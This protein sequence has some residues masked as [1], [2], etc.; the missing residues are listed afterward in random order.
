MWEEGA[1]IGS[2]CK[3][4][5]CPSTCIIH[6]PI[7]SRSY[8][9]SG[10]DHEIVKKVHVAQSIGLLTNSYL[11]DHLQ[12]FLTD[13][14]INGGLY[15]AEKYFKL[16]GPKTKYTREGMQLPQHWY[17]GTASQPQFL[18]FIIN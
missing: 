7:L 13:T 10:Q 3:A 8:N 12:F 14:R 15:V 5:L 6:M 9:P 16:Y 2:L 11:F 1:G 4:H 17:G 18:F